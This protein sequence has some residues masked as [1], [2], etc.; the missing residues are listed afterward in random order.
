MFFARLSQLFCI[1]GVPESQVIIFFFF[2]CITVRYVTLHSTRH[3]FGKN[4]CSM[5]TATK[6]NC[7]IRK[8]K[9][10]LYIP[11]TSLRRL[12]SPSPHI[13]DPLRYF[14]LVASDGA[15]DSIP[16]ILLLRYLFVSQGGTNTFFGLCF[17]FYYHGRATD[18]VQNM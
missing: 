10:D 12:R 4:N 8:L 5:N 14:W 2:Y 13:L 9:T 3:Y 7:K 11:L 6:K 15:C 16:C 17:L 1:I 18:D